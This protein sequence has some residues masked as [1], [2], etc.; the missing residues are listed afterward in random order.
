MRKSNTAAYLLYLCA[1]VL[2]SLITLL[3]FSQTTVHGAA[4]A[5]EECISMKSK[6]YCP[7]DY[8]VPHNVTQT[9]AHNSEQI[10]ALAIEFAKAAKVPSSCL[11][12]FK[13]MGCLA[14]YPQCSKEYPYGKPPCRSD[15]EKVKRA[16]KDYPDVTKDV[17]CTVLSDTNC[18]KLPNSANGV[19]SMRSSVVFMTVIIAVIGSTC[20]DSTINHRNHLKLQFDNT[21]KPF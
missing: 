18:A 14:I 20:K 4:A 6:G 21:T 1:L 7:L 3:S 16:C 17:D 15:C 9:D 13:P 11:N 5:G 12:M 19:V 2:V 8:R 10:L